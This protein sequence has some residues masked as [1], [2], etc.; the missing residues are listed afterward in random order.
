MAACGGKDVRTAKE[1][2]AELQTK[3]Q[4]LMDT[5]KEI[6][7]LEKELNK[8]GGDSVVERVV[9]VRV[10]ALQPELFEHEFEANGNVEARNSAFI[11]PE[12]GGQIKQVYVKEGQHVRQG[13]LLI[14]LNSQAVRSQ[15]E[16][17]DASLKL[18][19]T[20]YEKQKELWEQKIGS[21]VQYLEAKNKKESLESRIKSVKAQL[22][23][24]EI[25]AP[26]EGIVDEIYLKVGELATPG[27]R[28]LDLVNLGQMIVN[29]EVSEASIMTVHENDPVTVSLP[30]ISNWTQESRISRKGNIIN[31]ANR[32]FK[33]E[34]SLSNPGG[35]L[36]PNQVATVRMR[37]FYDEQAM[38]L[39][40]LIIRDDINGQYVFTVDSADSQPVARK[41]YIKTGQSYE[42][43]THV[44]S[45]LKTNDQVL[46]EGFSLVR[47]GSH[48][49][50]VK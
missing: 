21:E 18:A 38:V 17:L 34:V 20:I 22:D 3:H 19:T 44:L 11:S 13:Q 32:T 2:E 33:V 27:Q 10:K 8:L 1:V 49:E 7:D 42:G 9:K 14:S 50:I 6:A 45:G 41:T 12:I 40:A 39:P 46:V 26:F 31:P 25:K 15:L 28:L 47:D 16:E 24:T 36:K 4:L 29:A 5:K 23:M 35:D 30:N 48:I 43:R 37:D